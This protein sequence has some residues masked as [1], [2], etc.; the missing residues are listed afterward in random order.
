M[1]L[2]LDGRIQNTI[3]EQ[4]TAL[5]HICLASANL[6]KNVEAALVQ[7]AEEFA[8]ELLGKTDAAQLFLEQYPDEDAAQTEASDF[9]DEAKPELAPGKA[10]AALEVSVLAAPPGSAGERFRTLTRAALPE[11]EVLDATAEDDILF[12]REF[13]NLPLSELEQLGSAGQDAY[14]QMSAAEDFTPHVCIDVD[15]SVRS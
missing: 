5:V 9:F 3:R 8:G 4:F 7:T 13:S 12:Y 1:L 6:L 15:F 2:E 14:R 10:S 11:V